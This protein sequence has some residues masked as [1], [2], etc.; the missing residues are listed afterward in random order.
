MITGKELWEPVTIGNQRWREEPISPVT[1]VWNDKLS[2]VAD[3]APDLPDESRVIDAESL[4]NSLKEISDRYTEDR[5]AR[6]RAYA[7]ASLGETPS[8]DTDEELLAQ[9]RKSLSEQYGDKKG[10]LAEN[11]EEKLASYSAS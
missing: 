1:R 11:Y 9:A 5:R 8:F 6:A 10:S 4:L 2:D 7:E 3:L